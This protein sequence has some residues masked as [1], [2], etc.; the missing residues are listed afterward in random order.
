ME[1]KRIWEVTILL[2]IGLF[3]IN[4]KFAV[5]AQDENDT[6]VMFRN[7]TNESTWAGT[8]VSNP[9]NESDEIADDIASGI[10]P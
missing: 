10:F 7:H 8:N 5:Y 4:S 3:V 6:L 1:Q 9:I 2:F